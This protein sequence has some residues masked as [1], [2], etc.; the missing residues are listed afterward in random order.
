MTNTLGLMVERVLSGLRTDA[1][2]DYRW[3]RPSWQAGYEA[4]LRAAHEAVMMEMVRAELFANEPP[5]KGENGG[6]S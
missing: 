5:A 3:W 2:L 4:G 1:V 6:T